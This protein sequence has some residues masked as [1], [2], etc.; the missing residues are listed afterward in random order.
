MR[1][2]Y[3]RRE[4]LSS[5]QRRAIAERHPGEPLLVPG[6]ELVAAPPPLNVA[7]RTTHIHVKAF[8]GREV[9]TAQLYFPDDLIDG[10]YASV[11]PY[12]SHRLLTAPGL[13]RSYGRIRNGDDLFFKDSKAQPMTVTR[14][15]GVLVANAMI[16]M[17]SQGNRGLSTLFR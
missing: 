17:A 6:W 4:L 11:E 1:A 13:D 3:I 7:K 9:L 15:K 12:K 16:A 14:V 10:L 8:H 5:L 2:I